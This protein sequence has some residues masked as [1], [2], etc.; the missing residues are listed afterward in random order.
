MGGCTQ[1]M[2]KHRNFLYEG[3]DHLRILL[4]IWGFFYPRGPWSQSRE[5]IKGG[6]TI[7]WTWESCP[8]SHRWSQHGWC[9]SA[10]KT[11]FLGKYQ[12]AL[13]YLV[14]AFCSSSGLCKPQSANTKGRRGHPK[15]TNIGLLVNLNDSSLT[16][17]LIWLRKIKVT[18]LALWV[19][20]SKL[21]LL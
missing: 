3:L 4:T 16:V 20:W 15:L 6:L 8:N 14:C 1:V 18:C 11:S 13:M 21:H 5:D 2:W 17:D 12:K 7:L 19:P 9:N 10:N